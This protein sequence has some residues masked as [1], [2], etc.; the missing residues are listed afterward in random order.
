MME[1]NFAAQNLARKAAIKTREEKNFA[2]KNTKIAKGLNPS[3][4]SLGVFR[5]VHAVSAL[6]LDAIFN[7]FFRPVMP[8][9]KNENSLLEGSSLSPAAETGP[10]GSNGNPSGKID[11]NQ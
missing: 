7:Q 4:C 8:R 2:A 1:A 5:P 3:R 9:T 11:V 6:L 10:C